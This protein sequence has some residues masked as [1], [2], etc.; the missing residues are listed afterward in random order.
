MWETPKGWARAQP[1]L[2]GMCARVRAR[3]RLARR[4]RRPSAA[5]APAGA[6]RRCNAP[7][8]RTPRA[9]RRRPPTYRRSPR[10]GTPCGAPEEAAQEGGRG[11][12]DGDRGPAPARCRRTSALHF[13]HGRPPR[14]R[15]AN[16]KSPPPK[17]AHL[18]V[19]VVLKHLHVRCHA[20]TVAARRSVRVR[21]PPNKPQ[22]IARNAA[23]AAHARR[24]PGASTPARNV[25]PGPAHPAYASKQ[26]PPHTHRPPACPRCP[27]APPC[28]RPR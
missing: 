15:Q 12:R 5:A 25:P 19:P 28:A 17:R 4:S 27:R 22:T 11:V 18:H 2:A 7:G 13:P 21:K 16:R 6:R 10:G 23:A 9:A 26:P 8:A 1:R 14:P 3:G 20:S 24:V